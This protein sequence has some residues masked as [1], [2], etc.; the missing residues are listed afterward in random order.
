MLLI[1]HSSID[2][3][4]TGLSSLKI[5]V[6]TETHSLPEALGMIC[7]HALLGWPN[8][9][10]RSCRVEVLG[11]LLVVTQDQS[12]LL[13]PL[14]CFEQAPRSL[15]PVTAHD[16]YV[17]EPAPQTWLT[18]EISDFPFCHSPLPSSYAFKGSHDYI[19]LT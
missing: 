16:L 6:S 15:S 7:V 5:N 10:P 4:P 8:S 1:F 14:P 9:V 12:L 11:S 2:R 18:L 17:L 3:S 13:E 19:G